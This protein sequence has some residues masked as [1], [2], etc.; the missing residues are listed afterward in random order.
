MLK[1]KKTPGM[2]TIPMYTTGKELKGYQPKEKKSNELKV[3]FMTSPEVL[4]QWEME[5]DIMT[6]CEAKDSSLE[7]MKMSTLAKKNGITEIPTART[8]ERDEGR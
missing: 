3:Y 8:E 6:L 5:G 7:Q 4:K 1:E 2:I